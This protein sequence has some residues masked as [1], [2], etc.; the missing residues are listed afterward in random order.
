MTRWMWILLWCLSCGLASAQGVVNPHR[1]EFTASP[2][3]NTV[4]PDGQAAVTLYRLEIVAIGAQAA[5][6]GATL[7]KPTPDAQG[8]ITAS[9]QELLGTPLG[10]MFFARVIAVGP[11]GEAASDPSNPFGRFGP[12][13]P[14]REVKVVP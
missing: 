8:K 11:Q 4:L 10:Q 1:V 6:T 3:H 14:P 5:T 12:P 13:A 7:G 2:D 9:P